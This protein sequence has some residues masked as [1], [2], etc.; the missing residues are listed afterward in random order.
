M[1][2]EALPPTPMLTGVEEH[3]EAVRR[4]LRS[5]RVRRVV[6]DLCRLPG[7]L[8][9]RA[10]MQIGTTWC[11]QETKGHQE[12]RRCL[13]LYVRSGNVGARRRPRCRGARGDSRLA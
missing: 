13:P 7:Y 3:E 1:A 4:V 11:A 10:G 6:K 12:A 9:R 5:R 8:R 2:E